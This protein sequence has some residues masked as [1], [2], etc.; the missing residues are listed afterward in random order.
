M[1]SANANGTKRRLDA[2]S[3]KETEKR[4]FPKRPR[5]EKK[6]DLTRWRVRDD[7]GRL[8]WHYMLDEEAAKQWPQSYADKWYLGLP[9]VGIPKLSLLTYNKTV[10]SSQVINGS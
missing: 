3:E 8:T 1:T 5:L 4:D 6:T 2:S 7:E 9:M 10:T